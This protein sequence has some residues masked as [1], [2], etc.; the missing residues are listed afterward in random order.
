MRKIYISFSGLEIAKLLCGLAIKFY[1]YSEVS[2]GGALR[3]ISSSKPAKTWTHL[4]LRKA[5]C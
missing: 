5:K 1:C 3:E 2:F 4:A